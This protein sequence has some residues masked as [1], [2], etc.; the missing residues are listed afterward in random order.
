MLGDE[1]LLG[2][3]D[4]KGTNDD[5]DDDSIVQSRKRRRLESNDVTPAPSDFLDDAQ[6]VQSG[7]RDPTSVD[8]ELT[9]QIAPPPRKVIEFNEKLVQVCHDSLQPSATPDHLQHRFMV[10]VN[11]SVTCE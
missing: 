8:R 11:Y 3:H 9:N 2:S 6:S 1:D 5:D 7:S 10:N 4:N